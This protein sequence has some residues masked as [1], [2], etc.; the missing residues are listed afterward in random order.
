MIKDLRTGI[1][2][3]NCQLVLDG[4]IDIFIEAALSYKANQTN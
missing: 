1:E 2:S 3:S 4:E